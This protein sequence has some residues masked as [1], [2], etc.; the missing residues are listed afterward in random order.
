MGINAE[1][2][3]YRQYEELI[4]K[5]DIQTNTIKELTSTIKSLVEELKEEKDKNI[6]L[7]EL[8]EKALLEIERLKTNNKKDSSNSNK[9]S[10]SNGFKKVITNRREKSD[11]LQGGQNGHQF[12]SLSE[13]KVKE[14]IGKG[15][16]VEI[17][18]VNKNNSNKNGRYKTVKVI[19]IEIKVGIKEYRYYPDKFGNYNIPNNIQPISYGE[20]IKAVSTLLMNEFPNSTD[21]VKN[22]ISSL[23]NNGIDLSKGTLI[24]WN[25]SLANLLTPEIENIDRNLLNSHYLNVDESGIKIDGEN[26][27]QICASNETH[28]RLWVMKQKRHEDLE[29]ILLLLN[30]M[31]VIVKDGT[32]IYNGFGICF[33]QCISHILR[34]L[35]GLYD[36]ISHIGPRKMAEFLSRCIMQ[37]DELI[38][39]GITTFS[40]EKYNL[41]IKEYEDIIK[42]WKIEWMNDD[43]NH[44]YDEE[45]KLL[46]R[47][48]EDDKEQILYFLK[49]FKIPATNNQAEAD[50][51]PTKI[52]QKI[53]KFRSEEG[54]DNYTAI[55]SCI[56][57]YKKNKVNT[58]SALRN[59]FLGTPIIV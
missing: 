26:Y 32:D 25:S 22:I 2:S 58:L 39:K 1:K 41:L 47:M 8:L 10:G 49:D 36:F 23:T 45:R 34:Y 59:A 16:E 5:F 44:L 27:N 50:Q 29:T 46:S 57:T 20:N 14:L 38:A 24:N 15:A 13:D 9:P 21:G 54:A 42:I 7:Q 19:D 52:K 4:E 35:K 51:R 55:R 37:R 3:L 33:S 53:G 43:K 56:N 17:I 40:S 6:K 30:F 12:Y 31:G 28:T 48:E 11:K 18:E